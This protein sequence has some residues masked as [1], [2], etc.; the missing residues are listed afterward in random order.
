MSTLTRI[1][2]NFSIKRWPRQEIRDVVPR[3]GRYH[4]NHGNSYYGNSDHG[5]SDHGT[6]VTVTMVTVTMV[7]VTMVT[8][9]MATLTCILSL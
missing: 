4:D 6:M 9:T 7:T 1:F 2:S 5:N 3:A 8:V